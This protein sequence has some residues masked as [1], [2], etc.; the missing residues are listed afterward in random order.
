MKADTDHEMFDVGVSI[1]VLYVIGFQQEPSVPSKKEAATQRKR[2]STKK[3]H[4][5]TTLKLL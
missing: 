5:A 4:S 3:Q 2:Q 1:S